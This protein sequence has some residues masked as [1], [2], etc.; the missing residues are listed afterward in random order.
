MA[1]E[2]ETLVYAQIKREL[3]TQDVDEVCMMKAIAESD[4]DNAKVQSAYIRLRAEDLKE[5][6]RLGKL[7]SFVSD[8]VEKLKERNC[9]T[10]AHNA[11]ARE[12]K[13]ILRKEAEEKRL[14][15]IHDKDMARA[16]KASKKGTFG[17]MGCLTSF[18]MILLLVTFFIYIFGNLTGT[19]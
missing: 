12:Q 4:G 1:N 17:A 5:Q 15:K 18:I 10:D 11:R 16:K 8:T 6:Y 3:D 14:K 9:Q 7:K 2:I 13:E 19:G